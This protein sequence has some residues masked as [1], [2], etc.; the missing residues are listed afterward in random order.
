MRRDER[1]NKEGYLRDRYC[2]T[3]SQ[4]FLYAAHQW[5]HAE[6]EG[7]DRAPDCQVVHPRTKKQCRREDNHSGK[8]GYVGGHGIIWW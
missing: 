6:E 1:I 7:H 4:Y 5:R 2:P 3:C 8:H